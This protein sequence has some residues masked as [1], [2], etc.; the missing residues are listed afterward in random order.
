MLRHGWGEV[1]WSFVKPPYFVTHFRLAGALERGQRGKAC[2]SKLPIVLLRPQSRPPAESLND[3]RSSRLLETVTHGST[4]H[5]HGAMAW[6]SESKKF[7][8]NFK[9]MQFSS[10]P[11]L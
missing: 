6:K 1:A 10:Y 9:M 2:L 7:N 3:V 4:V 11:S 5:G 8:L